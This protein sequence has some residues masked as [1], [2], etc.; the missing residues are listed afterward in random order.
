M[1]MTH[2]AADEGAIRLIE[3]R[4]NAAWNRHHPTDMAESLVDDAQFVT[5][6][7]VW[8]KSRADFQRLM[9]QL[10]GGPFKTSQRET[11]E[12]DIRFLSP[13]IAIVVSQFRIS[14]DVT[15][16]GQAITREGVGIRVVHKRHGNW[17]TVAVQNTDVANRRTLK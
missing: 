5:V 6:N 11:F 17:Q 12:S 8:T 9:E 14:N 15:E 10:H 7:G 3:D 13:E 4:F 1:T 16:Q 2:T